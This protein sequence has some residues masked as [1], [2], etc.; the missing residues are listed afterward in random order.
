MC[1]KK[2]TNSIQTDSGF[3]RTFLPPTDTNWLLF[4]IRQK[5]IYTV[6]M[7]TKIVRCRFFS[8]SEQ[9]KTA[10]TMMLFQLEERKNGEK[11]CRYVWD[12]CSVWKMCGIYA[13]GWPHQW[14]SWNHAKLNAL[15]CL[16]VMHTFNLLNDRTCVQCTC[17]RRDA[18]CAWF[19]FINVIV[20]FSAYFNCFDGKCARDIPASV[21]HLLHVYVCVCVLGVSFIIRSEFVVWANAVNAHVFT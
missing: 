15:L 19:S 2:R 7:D 21:W 3:F 9:Q 16:S 8:L 4:W 13:G 17:I 10:P 5:L 20:V 14:K 1:R 6:H 12:I 11:N 18:V